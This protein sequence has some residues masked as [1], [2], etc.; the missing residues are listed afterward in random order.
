MAGL[1]L[2]RLR[3]KDCSENFVNEED[4]E[5]ISNEIGGKTIIYQNMMKT[6][7]VKL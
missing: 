7:T 6:T 1:F 3:K 5:D 4:V 2:K